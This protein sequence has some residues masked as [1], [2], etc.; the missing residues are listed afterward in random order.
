VPIW[1]RGAAPIMTNAPV[2]TGSRYAAVPVLLVLSAFIVEADRF[3]LRGR[4]LR[5]NVG[6]LFCCLLFVPCWVV[7]LRTPN[8]RSAGPSWSSQVSKATAACS[9]KHGLI[10][11]LSTSPSGWITPIPC[12]DLQ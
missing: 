8:G 2:Q 4:E 12:S 1:I 11:S 3:R 9:E 7:D 10:H 5:A 6:I